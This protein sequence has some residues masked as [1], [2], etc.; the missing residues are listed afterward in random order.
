MK[1]NQ[2]KE[3]SYNVQNI[4][5]IYRNINNLYN[6]EFT[7]K[8]LS[9]ILSH[10][11]LKELSSLNKPT[12]LLTVGKS[13][14]GKTFMVESILNRLKKPFIMTD[15]KQFSEVGY[16]GK[17]LI[18]VFQEFLIKEDYNMEAVENGII[19]F[20]EFDKLR[21]K[22]SSQR[23]I[24]G[25]SIQHSLLKILDGIDIT[26]INND[27]RRS[28]GSQ[29]HVNTSNMIFI[30]IGAFSYLNND[31]SKIQQK[32]IDTGFS[33]EL[34]NRINYILETKDYNKDVLLQ[35]LNINNP[36]SPLHKYLKLFESLG[37]TLVF[38]NIEQTLL[39]LINDSFK[40]DYSFRGIEFLV[41]NMFTPYICDVI[42]NNV[43][44]IKIINT[45]VKLIT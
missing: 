10:E 34:I 24:S 33:L 44:E 7:K 13:G 42:I 17:D 18:D 9:I 28:M 39:G 27:N 6:D 19:I 35:Y 16:Q 41:N 38:E 5:D 30:F 8:F 3:R 23:D 43:R 4:I 21:A 45:Q 31:Y 32:L 11:K 1:I 2:T 40:I 29:I 12:T 20:D 14:S 15:I 37:C 36:V 25:L 22:E 26:I